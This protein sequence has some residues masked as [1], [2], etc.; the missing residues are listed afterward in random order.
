MG[1]QFPATE[2][3][4]D[5]RPNNVGTQT[6]AV[7][8]ALQQ[9]APDT[10]AALGRANRNEAPQD[11]ALAAQLYAQ[12]GPQFFGIGEDLAD[13]Q[14]GRNVQRD[15]STIRGG[16]R[17]LAGEAIGLD[18]LANPEFYANRAVAGRG[19]QDL[20]GG[21]DPNKL[22]GG[23]MANVERGINRLNTSRGTP[24]N[25]G[26]ATTTASNA[27]LFG[28]KLNKKRELFGQSLALFPGIQQGSQSGL[29]TYSIAKGGNATGNNASL[30]QLQGP[31][32][33]DV[34]ALFGGISQGAFGLQSQRNDIMSQR[35]DKLDRFNETNPCCFI[36]MEAT[37]G[38]L[39]ASVRIC[40]DVYYANEPL[41][42][43]GYKRM[44]K[45]LVPAMKKSSVVKW[46][47]NATM[48]KPLTR[49]GEWLV[50][51]TNTFNKFDRIMRNAWFNIWRLYA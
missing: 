9:G 13:I 8:Q 26:D 39:P 32:Q 44:A 43:R 1:R 3:D 25:I 29:D 14:A 30:A 17:E 46:L 38:E 15:L 23:E 12:Y 45:W 7:L 21:Q 34:N 11:A 41:L 22:T 20:I 2:A 18:Q 33:T 37:N 6:R 28:D 24:S 10:L 27:M 47:V 4:E 49:Y 42:G 5:F 50:G 19:F 36:F 16:G 35:R 40:R 31:Q 48:V 51:N